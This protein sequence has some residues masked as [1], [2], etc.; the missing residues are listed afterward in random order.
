MQMQSPGLVMQQILEFDPGQCPS[1][2]KPPTHE[3][4]VLVS[5][6]VP[7][8]LPTLQ[9]VLFSRRFEAG[10]EET[11]GM[12]ATVPIKGIITL[13]SFMMFEKIFVVTILDDRFKILNCLREADE[14]KS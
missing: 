14:F 1:T 5:T 6:H 4:P 9:D 12:A 13:R 11:L 3:F 2:K 7:D 10:F 8:K